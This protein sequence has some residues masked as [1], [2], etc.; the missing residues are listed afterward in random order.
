LVGTS[1]L[2]W[3]AY[4]PSPDDY[5]LLAYTNLARAD[6]GQQ[7]LIWHNGLGEAAKSHSDDVAA[8]GC[9]SHDS[10][11]G[12]VWWR[13][14]QRY[15]PGWI[16]LG[17]NIAGGGNDPADFH[18]IWM[19]SPGHRAN[20]LR[21]SYSEFGAGISVSS[22]ANGSYTFGTQDFGSRGSIALGSLPTLPA[23]GVVPRIHYPTRPRQLLV[24]YYHHGGG[25]PERIRALVGN[26][27]VNL[28]KI[29]G[30]ASNGTYG[31]TRTFSDPCTPVVFEAIRSDGTRHRWP[32]DRAIVVGQVS[33][34]CPAFTTAVPTQDCGGGGGPAPTPTPTPTPDPGPGPGDRGSE[35]DGVRVV[36]KPGKASASKGTV[37]LQAM[38][39]A[40]PGFDPT[41]SP[42]GIDLT[43]GD[44]EEW[45][46]TLPVL[47]NGSLCLRSNRQGTAWTGKYDSSR[48]ISFV[49][50]SGDRWKVRFSA[51][52]QTLGTLDPGEVTVD[53]TVGGRTYGASATG[54]IREHGLVAD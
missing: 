53:I 13:R 45:S 52:N 31:V 28:T 41:S 19:S 54:E 34:A 26:S 18:A 22:P 35:L 16:I 21:S 50:T 14:I 17:E 5:A 25:A 11:S 23:G 48:A 42:I 10:C 29:A 27:C 4:A 40:L 46:T 36:M 2:G 15:Y 38:L 7:P 30:S 24:N 32:T 33:A 37:Q 44:S 3:A 20:I 47:C 1:N 12:T 51:R 49:K 39:P 8:S 9:F 6:A 43:F